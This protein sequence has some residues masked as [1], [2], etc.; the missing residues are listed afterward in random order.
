M[1]MPSIVTHNNS[2]LCQLGLLSEGSIKEAV[3]NHSAGNVLTLTIES[4]RNFNGN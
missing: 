4:L 3:A 2:D 1:Q